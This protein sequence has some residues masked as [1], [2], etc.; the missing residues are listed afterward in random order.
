MNDM[1]A[2]NER[3]LGKTALFAA[4][5]FAIVVFITVKNHYI[6]YQQISQKI[7]AE[8]LALFVVI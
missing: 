2:M 5:Y 3:R 4:A 8:L 6:H 7:I 1:E